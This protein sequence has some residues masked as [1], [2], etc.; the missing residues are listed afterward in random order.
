MSSVRLDLQ[1][2]SLVL[3]SVTAFLTFVIIFVRL[4]QKTYTGFNFWVVSNITV[5]IGIL[6][7]GIDGNWTDIL[8]TSLT[9]GAVLIGY[10]GN[11]RFL[12]LKH[13]LFLSSG[14]FFLQFAALVYF[15]FF[16]DN[17]VVS[18]VSFTSFSVGVV[19][20]FCGFVFARNYSERTKFSY[21]FTGITYFIFALIMI[22][23]SLVTLFTGDKNDFYKPDGIQPVFFILYILFEIVWTFN[24]INLNANRLQNELRQTQAELEKLATT[25]FLTG[26]HN[27]R[28]FLQIGENEL[29][30]AKRFRHPLS[31]I[32]FDI[33]FF[34][35]INDRF[36]HAAG[37][38]VLIEIAATCRK[39]LRVTDTFGR[40]GGEEFAVLLPHT[41]VDDAKTVAEYLRVSIEQMRIESVSK[42]IK[43]T[44][45]F[46]IAE[47]SGTDA[48]IKTTLDRADV[49]LYEAKNKGRN[50]IASDMAISENA[51][52]P[53]KQLAAA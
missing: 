8:G 17:N 6:L 10:E 30:R 44:A 27:Q 4:T 12:K 26:I 2:L 25:D 20:I 15:K 11:R 43:V 42:K 13:N 33:D 53:S 51:G 34:K 38:T 46:G 18:Q 41:R 9:F 7:L 52:N 50:R 16:D 36:G 28:S 1:T 19:S 31:V 32:M 24:Y 29:Q 39:I 5:A 45:S 14:I 37:D 23:R 48:Q 40:L 21:N 22:A 3:V 35:R 49:F 47:L